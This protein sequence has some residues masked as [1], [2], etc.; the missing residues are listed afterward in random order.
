[1]RHSLWPLKNSV[2]HGA[3]IRYQAS[4]SMKGMRTHLTE[5]IWD[6][7]SASCK[8][9]R[10]NQSLEA[11]RYVQ[12]LHPVQRFSKITQACDRISAQVTDLQPS[13][14]CTTAFAAIKSKYNTSSRSSAAQQFTSFSSKQVAE[15]H[16]S[17]VCISCQGSPHYA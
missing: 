12:I 6:I 11:C 14:I 16:L 8:Q 1:M 13:R 7:P 4:P 17:K 2:R 5:R 3:S 15:H 9:G 10:A